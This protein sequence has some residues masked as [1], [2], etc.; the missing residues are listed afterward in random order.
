MRLPPPLERV[1]ASL[2]RLPGVGER[3]AT[4][5][6]F[7]LLAQAPTLAAELGESLSGLHTAVRHCAQCHNLATAE[8]CELCLDPRRD[9]SRLCVVEGLPELIAIERTGEFNGHYHVLHG[10][11]SPVR[12]IGPEALKLPSLLERVTAQSVTEVILA[13]NADVEGEATAMYVARLLHRLPQVAV[14]RLATGVPM[15][16]DLEFVDQ[17]T[18]ARAVRDRRAL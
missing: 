13:T 15:G 4:R 18:L 12:G 8:R 10:T 3:T 6:A 9:A 16:G 11:L 14:S 17:G 2:A 5:Y 7:F 1:V